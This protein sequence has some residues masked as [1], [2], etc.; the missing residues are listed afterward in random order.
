MQIVV[1]IIIILLIV[2]LVWLLR[3]WIKRLIFILILLAL[4]FLIYGI[5]NPS[6]AA[7][8]WYNVRTFPERMA[9][10]MWSGKEF[11]DYDRYKLNI[12]SIGDKIEGEVWDKI[13]LG[14]DEDESDLELDNLELDTEDVEIEN[15]KANDIEQ[16]DEEDIYESMDKRAIKAFPRSIKFIDFSQLADKKVSEADWS[17]EWYSKSDLLLV[18]SK[19]I[20]DNLD[21]DTDILVTVEYEDEWDKPQRVILET[22]PKT[23]WN[24]QS[25][26]FS[27]RLLGNDSVETER[28][29]EKVSDTSVDVVVEKTNTQ[30][31]TKSV[32][33]TTSNNLTQKEQKEAEEIFSILF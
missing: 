15:N 11:L 27:S 20:E 24:K 22:R 5:F 21:D 17:L 12:S 23:S 14:D 6:W 30:K 32:Q 16:V 31:N 2:F 29:K 25:I 13:D 26:Y 28:E 19:Y 4:A 9:S 7:R 10:W 8:I 1:W 33:R 3:R 18:I